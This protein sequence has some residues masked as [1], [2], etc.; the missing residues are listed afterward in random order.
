MLPGL[1]A[2]MSIWY[3]VY[4]NLLV[5]LSNICGSNIH[6][7]RSLNTLHSASAS[8]FLHP[9]KCVALSQLLLAI[10]RAQI[11]LVTTLHGMDLLLPMLF[12]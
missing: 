6:S 11:C 8:T 3:I 2:T 4:S 1:D 7:V 5:I 10:R 9:G 12:M